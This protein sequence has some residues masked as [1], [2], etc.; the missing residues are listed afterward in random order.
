MNPVKPVAQHDTDGDIRAQRHTYRLGIAMVL[1]V[2]LAGLGHLHFAWHRYHANEAL[3][4]INLGDTVGA[5]LNLTDIQALSASPR[6]MDTEAYQNIY[7]SLSRMVKVNT[8]ISH[9]YLVRVEAGATVLLLESAPAQF[10]RKSS[11]GRIF[12]DEQALIDAAWTSTG[13]LFTDTVQNSQGSWLSTLTPIYSAASAQPVAILGI[14]Y[15]LAPW[16]KHIMEHMLTDVL[17]VLSVIVLT[18]A[19]WRIFTEHSSLQ[20]RSRL[21]ARDKALFH[22]VFEQAPIG[23][24]IGGDDRV[25]YTSPDGRFSVNHM[26]EVILGR[27][28]AE[29]EQTDW[30]DITHPDDLQADL[31]LLARYK[32]GEIDRYTIEK[33]FIRPDGSTVW[34]NLTIGTLIGDPRQGK[35][36]LCILEDITAR[37][38]AEQAL[39]ESERGKAVLLSHLPGLAYRCKY[40]RNWTM[41]FVSQGCE[42]LTGYAPECLVDNRDISFGDL[43]APEYRDLLWAEWALALTQNRHFRHEY[44]IITH[45]GARKW[46]L[47]H[48]QFI[49]C[50][51]GSVEALEGIVI[52]ISELKMRESQISYLNEHD[53]LT[54]LY[55]RGHFEQA[56]QRL[57]DAAY[58]P[59][60]IA[61]CDINGVRLVND[62]F[63]LGEGDRLITDV[64]HILQTY[65]RTGDV[66]CRT[67]GDDFTLL[68][69]CTT[70]EQAVMLVEGIAR[71]V[72]RYNQSEQ[73][74]LVEM[75]LS[76]GVCTTT[77]G[78]TLDQALA[79]AEERLKHRKIL[80]QK[81]SHSAILSSIMATLYARS[82]ETEEHGKRLTHLTRQI[83]EKMG[84]DT[85]TLDDL[86]L[87]S[88]LHDIGKVG[89][90]DHILNKPARLDPEEWELM[91]HHSEIG[92]RIAL[93]SPE[94]E[95]IAIYILSHHEQ[96]D[97]LGYPFG[98]KGDAIPLPARILTVA[99]AYDAM[100]E[101]RVY[102]L[103]MPKADAVA[104]IARCAGTQFDPTVAQ[105]VI[106]LL[107]QQDA[108]P[109]LPASS[110][111]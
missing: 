27:T 50:A 109:V 96:W 25:T 82:Q 101:D 98:L 97:G 73:A 10:T 37:K 65:S 38:N 48:G 61:V 72:E 8:S 31:A 30:H 28:K 40:D 22:S 51:D 2:F 36:H 99:D 95:H 110:E 32:A 79:A 91:K 3:K 80:T 26:Y 54:G 67:G 53:F 107:A 18:L 94:L 43:I 60:T 56:K 64:A 78:M 68:L 47:E 42:T 55:N 77:E 102:R 33:R 104:E 63:G 62:A 6:D 39:R 9:A 52:D 14:T 24:S 90:S 85:G 76:F 15:P 29:L 57:A 17:V 93:S 111:Q 20:R 81:S 16:N 5:L 1:V 86:E 49:F 58:M 12:R 11:P 46:V 100:T 75:S 7:Q 71:A 13:T 89:I 35:Q 88:M 108:A 84:L 45:E 66:L 19:L 69:P 83:G 34:A 74:R 44:E 59:L 70:E 87:L 103:A 105:I 4:V 23:I 41:E 106:E 92:Y 21:L